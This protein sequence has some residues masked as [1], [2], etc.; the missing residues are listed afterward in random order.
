M[1]EGLSI[2]NFTY[3]R[4]RFAFRFGTAYLTFLAL[5]PLVRREWLYTHQYQA[6]LLAIPSVVAFFS[7]IF[8]FVSMDADLTSSRSAYPAF[9]LRLPVTTRALAAWPIFLSWAYAVIVWVA[10]A[11]L[12]LNQIKPE[13]PNGIDRG[14]AV[15]VTAPALLFAAMTV[16]V[17]AVLW[18]PMR[19][20][21]L[22]LIA[23]L[24]LLVGLTF[25]GIPLVLSS[26]LSP[27]GI[28]LVVGGYTLLATWAG[29]DSVYRSRHQPSTRFVASA[30][31]TRS[32][33]R[34][35][36]MKPFSSPVE[37]QTWIEWRRQGRI[38]PILTFII[39][40]GPT[41]FV[42]YFAA[43][44]SLSPLGPEAIVDAKVNSAVQSLMPILLWVPV[45]CRC[46]RRRRRLLPVPSRT[47]ADRRADL[48][49]SLS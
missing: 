25:I 49:R 22:R 1:K 17:Q 18:R 14:W 46:P 19:F 41:G 29:F 5:L 11:A 4:Q 47:F 34:Q 20:G 16:T 30:R 33:R 3:Q 38:L 43:Q 2:L 48:C 39:L 7:C 37:A 44:G 6:A 31:K 40:L 8:G 35:S 23:A 13:T 12:Y 24:A 21:L 9:L 27:T 32:A 15:P 36:T 42:W 10:F 28:K 45:L 26:G